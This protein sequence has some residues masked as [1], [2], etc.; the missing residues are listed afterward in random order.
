MLVLSVLLAAYLGFALPYSWQWHQLQPCRDLDIRVHQPAG[1]AKPFVTRAQVER[2]L[3]GWHLD[4]TDLPITRIN[5]FNIQQHLDAVDNIESSRAVRLPDGTI[6][7]DVIPMQP[8]ARVFV[9]GSPFSYYINRQGKHLTA[10]SRFHIDVPV[11]TARFDSLHPAADIVPLILRIEADDDWR[12]LVS[13]VNV[14]TLTGDIILVPMIRGHV[15]NLGDLSDLDSK[16]SRILTMYRQVLPLRG[17]QTYDTLSVK[18][19]GQVVATRRQ[20]ELPPIAIDYADDPDNPDDDGADLGS[21]LA[22][23]PQAPDT[24]PHD[25]SPQAPGTH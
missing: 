9:P 14:D 11:V 25:V 7:V 1:Q 18:Y 3:Q 13:Q 4:R 12:A 24:V 21:M 10:N 15:I 8:V 23:P 2:M 17:W 22:S 20:K 19:R 16:L 5:T 6:R